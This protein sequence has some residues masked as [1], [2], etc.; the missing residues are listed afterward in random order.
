MYAWIYTSHGSVGNQRER[1]KEK[2]F[3]MKVFSV[4]IT[5]DAEKEHQKKFPFSS[6][7][8]PVGTFLSHKRAL[9]MHQA[10]YSDPAKKKAPLK[11][12]ST[13]IWCCDMCSANVFLHNCRR[14]CVHARI[15]V[16]K[17]RKPR[18]NRSAHNDNN[19]N[20]I[21]IFSSNPNGV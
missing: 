15:I 13:I 18:R 16:K 21:S 6:S 4:S 7:V 8:A 9:N 19:N 3:T 10:I 12:S 2:S 20:Y 11:S 14:R 1:Q 5:L 17:K